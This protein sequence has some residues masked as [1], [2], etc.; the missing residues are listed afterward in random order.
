MDGLVLSVLCS[1]LQKCEVVSLNI[2]HQLTSRMELCFSGW[3]PQQVGLGI[4]LLALNLGL[5]RQVDNW[6]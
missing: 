2:F 6:T 4:M 1:L 5:T 3:I